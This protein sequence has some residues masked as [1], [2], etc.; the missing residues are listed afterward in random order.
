MVN[1]SVTDVRWWSRAACVS[2]FDLLR[3]RFLVRLLIMNNHHHLIFIYGT[4]RRGGRAHHLMQAADFQSKGLASG[5]LVHVDQYPG[6]IPCDDEQ[7]MGE[8]YL[9]NDQ[10]LNELDRYEGCLESPPHYLRQ[11]TMVLLENGEKR[12]AMV[13]TFQLLESHHEEIKNGDWIQW[14]ESK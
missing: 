9:L 11:E 6:L 1:I 4:L 8:L 12:S 3:A 5:R 13:Y 10:L 14:I 2:S 7:V